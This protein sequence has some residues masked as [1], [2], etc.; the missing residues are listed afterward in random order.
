MLI[1]DTGILPIPTGYWYSAYT[2][3]IL[4]YCYTD[5]MS[6]QSDSA[7]LLYGQDTDILLYG[8]DTAIPYTDS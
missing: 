5:R 7:I 2:D 8:Q 6:R 1:L 4:V 3:R